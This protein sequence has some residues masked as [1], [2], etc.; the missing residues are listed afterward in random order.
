MTKRSKAAS[1]LLIY[2]NSLNKK[3]S[4]LLKI[5]KLEK[6]D[7]VSENIEH[8]GIHI[9]YEKNITRAIKKY[10]DTVAIYLDKTEVDTG[11]TSILSEIK[12]KREIANNLSNINIKLLKEKMLS[13]KIK[14]NSFK[15]PKI[16]RRVYYTNENNK[17]MDI[18]I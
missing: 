16:G 11:I 4:E 12:E 1:T 10:T 3:Y 7:I 13:L 18:E 2:S 17:I 9:D 6:Q 15:L 14:I 5:L 8:L